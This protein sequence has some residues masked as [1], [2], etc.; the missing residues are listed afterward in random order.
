MQASR[1]ASDYSPGP[2]AGLKAGQSAPPFSV[3]TLDDKPLRLADYRGKYVL[4]DF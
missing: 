3:K 1:R 4:L 2:A